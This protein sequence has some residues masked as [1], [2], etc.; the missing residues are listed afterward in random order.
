MALRDA[1][2]KAE[3]AISIVEIKS[4][5]EDRWEKQKAGAPSYAL[6]T[7]CSGVPMLIERIAAS[8]KDPGST[9]GKSLGAYLLLPPMT[10]SCPIFWTPLYENYHFEEEVREKEVVFSYVLQKGRTAT[11]QKC[12]PASGYAGI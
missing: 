10:L 11:S 5:K 7:R 8:L 4:L 3:R 9:D 12:D 2:L 1:T 6:S